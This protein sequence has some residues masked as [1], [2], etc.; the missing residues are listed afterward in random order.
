MGQCAPQ[1][2]PPMHV[3][4]SP[5][6]PSHAFARS[7]RRSP[8]PPS[9]PHGLVYPVPGALLDI[10]TVRLGMERGLVSWP[11][12]NPSHEAYMLTVALYALFD[13]R[14]DCPVLRTAVDAWWRARRSVVPDPEAEPY[15]PRMWWVE[16]GP[17]VWH[18]LRLLREAVP[19]DRHWVH[20]R[21]EDA[22]V[23]L[24]Y[25]L[26]HEP[27]PALADAIPTLDAW[28]A[29]VPRAC[30][31]SSGSLPAAHWDGNRLVWTPTDGP[32]VVLRWS[33][34][35]AFDDI[36]PLTGVRD[37]TVTLLP[38]AVDLSHCLASGGGRRPH[39]R[40]QPCTTICS[41]TARRPTCGWSSCI[42]CGAARASSR[43][44]ANARVLEHAFWTYWTTPGTDGRRPCH[45]RRFDAVY[46]WDLARS[47]HPPGA[48]C[49]RCTECRP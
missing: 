13:A 14:C 10:E 36:P 43:P 8:R 34:H 9:G 41:R 16:H 37:I 39:P 7:G 3:G 32:A 1:P 48:A 49:A 47:R 35:A 12:H 46:V 22:A 17:S 2:A 23:A 40:A 33:W 5:H 15:F 20:E 21:L 24:R 29:G 44:G 11:L 18:D 28:L 30:H 42:P 19:P 25:V 31:R 45:R 27:L 6:T 38:G 26:E 4:W